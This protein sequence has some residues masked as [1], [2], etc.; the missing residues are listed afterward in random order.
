MKDRLELAMERIDQQQELIDDLQ[1]DN[2]HLR[3]VRDELANKLRKLTRIEEAESEALHKMNNECEKLV[4]E[5]RH[6]HRVC[7]ATHGCPMEFA[8]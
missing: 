6:K 3:K 8:L 1:R 4:M 5:A 7:A 2:I